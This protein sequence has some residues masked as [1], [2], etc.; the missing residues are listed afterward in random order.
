MASGA[1]QGPG[2]D[3][4]GTVR[5]ESVRF[6][7][8]RRGLFSRGGPEVVRDVS[9]VVAKGQ[10]LGLVGESGSGK[11]TIGRVALGVYPPTSGRALFGGVP[12]ER[13]RRQLKGRFQVVLQN[14]EWSL[15]PRLRIGVSVAEPLTVA[16]V[17]T[18]AERRERVGELLELVGLPEALARRYPHELSGGQQQR[19]AIARALITQPDFIV[20]DEAVS[21]LDV[22]VQAQ[23]LNLIKSLQAAAGFAA[24]FISHDMA[25]VRYVSDSVAVMMNGEIVELAPVQTFYGNPGHP[26]SRL[27]VNSVVQ[28]GEPPAAGRRR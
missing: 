9:L 26:Y 28:G 10:T 22:S 23:T 6:A 12:I 25:A 14:P 20:F 17:G 21:A 2:G 7:Y 3:E 4:R 8:G 19:V 1:V 15:N 24:L 11:S 16:K 27:L 13:Q 5:L 18:R